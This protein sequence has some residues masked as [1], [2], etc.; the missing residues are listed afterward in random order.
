MMLSEETH[1]FADELLTSDRQSEFSRA[2]ENDFNLIFSRI[3]EITS[4]NIDD[5]ELIKQTLVTLS[6]YLRWI[7][8]NVIISAPLCRDLVWKLFP[9]Q[10]FRYEVLMCFDSIAMHLTAAAD[11]NM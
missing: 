11:Q 8:L 1:E 9:N 2:L 5:V 4:S 6:H 3:E 7:D 10:N